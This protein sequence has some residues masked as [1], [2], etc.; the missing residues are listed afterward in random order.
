[1]KKLISILEL[2]MNL[3]NQCLQNMKHTVQGG[4]VIQCLDSSNKP[5]NIKENKGETKSLKSWKE[6]MVFSNNVS[7]TFRRIIN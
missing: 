7:I 3:I 6:G 4:R 5:N 2:L 1:M